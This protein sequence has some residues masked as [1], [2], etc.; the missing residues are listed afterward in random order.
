MTT[1]LKRVL[2]AYNFGGLNHENLG[3]YRAASAPSSPFAGQFWWDTSNNIFKVYNANASAWVALASGIASI[4]QGSNINVNLTD[5]ANPIVSVIINDAGTSGSDLWSAE[6]ITSYV[7]TAVT[8]LFEIKGLLDCS[9]N[10]NYP[11][12]SAGDVYKVSVAGR[13][14]GASGPVVEVGDL[15]VAMADNA[16]GSHASVGASWVIEQNNINVAALAG[17]GLVYSGGTLNVNPDDESLELNGS[18][19][20]VK[21]SGITNAMLAGSIADSKLDQ[22]STTNK[23]AGSAV[24]LASGSAISDDSGLKV[25]VDGSTL[26]VS[27]GSIQQKDGGTTYAKLAADAKP[28]Y[29]TFATTDFST[30]AFTIAAATHGKGA[31]DHL[32]IQVFSTDEASGAATDVTGQV[33]VSANTSTGAITVTSTS[34]FNGFVRVSK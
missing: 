7:T 20:R 30:G 24:Q 9:S 3:A 18:S 32:S 34:D 8:N 13:V 26:E 21:A 17:L 23:V 14:G 15:V 2:S 22:I 33:I 6:Q 11:A 10:P 1:A 28:T 31:T 4:A 29:V 16:G 5:P 25:N 12:A 27:A 19:L